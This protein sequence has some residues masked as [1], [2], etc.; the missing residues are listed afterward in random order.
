MSTG[1]GVSMAEWIVGGAPEID[2]S[3]LDPA[4]FLQP[5]IGEVDLL[6]QS[7]WQYENYYTP[8]G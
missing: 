5:E 7:V 4:R 6:S 1:L 8:L 3:I 2:L